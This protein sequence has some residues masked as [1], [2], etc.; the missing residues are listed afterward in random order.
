MLEEAN[1][2]AIES[3]VSCF[4]SPG[5]IPEQPVAI[6]LD[7]KKIGPAER[8]RLQAEAQ[9]FFS[10]LIADGRFVELARTSALDAAREL[11][12]P[13]SPQLAHF[14]DTR[15]EWH[16]GISKAAAK[17]SGISDP[18]MGAPIVIIAVVI[19][20]ATPGTANEHGG[21]VI[22]A[23]NDPCDDRL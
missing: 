23:A 10:A 18:E 11:Q 8:E 20:F 5:F 17:M 4:Q 7:P 13:L 12:H 1:V 14:L 21:S 9:E 6:E 16:S 2:D 19:V 22:M 3:E 15:N